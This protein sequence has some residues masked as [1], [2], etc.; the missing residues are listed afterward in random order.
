MPLLKLPLYP[1]IRADR[2]KQAKARNGEKSRRRP[3]S[4][5]SP[6]SRSPLHQARKLL[7]KQSVVAVEEEEVRLLVEFVDVA[8]IAGEELPGAVEV[9][10]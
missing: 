4:G 10:L 1:H 7:D 2:G 9:V 6:R 5:L 8:Q 3:K